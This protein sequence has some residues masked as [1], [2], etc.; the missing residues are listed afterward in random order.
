MKKQTSTKA[1]FVVKT[2]TLYLTG[3]IHTQ[4]KS[5]TCTCLT[6]IKLLQNINI[7]GCMGFIVITLPVG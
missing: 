2:L 7:T 3:I 1:L 5:S 4:K 6:L